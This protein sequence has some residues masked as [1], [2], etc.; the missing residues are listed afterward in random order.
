[1]KAA[2]WPHNYQGIKAQKVRVNSAQIQFVL[3]ALDEPKRYRTKW[4]KQNYEGLTAREEAEDDLR[5]KWVQELSFI[6]LGTKTPL[7]ITIEQKPSDIQLL[8]TGRRA[9][10]SHAC[11][12]QVKKFLRWLTVAHGVPL[13]IHVMHLTGYLQLR[14]LEPCNRGA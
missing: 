11:V 10:T 14:D 3:A 12:G 4:Q 5:S 7:G 9:G 2:V 1:M 8:G 13:P 6:L